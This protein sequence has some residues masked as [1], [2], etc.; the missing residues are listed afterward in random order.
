MVTPSDLGRPQLTGIRILVVD[1]DNETREL[2]SGSLGDLGA[3]VVRASSA[4]E[5]RAEIARQRPDAIVSD[6][7]MPD[8]DGLAFVRSLKNQAEHA[9][10]TA[11]ASTKD[12]DEALNAGY[13]EHVAKPVPPYRLARVI[14]AA[15]RP[16]S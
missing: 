6:I 10:L 7:G 12:R 14:I 3:T 15:L 9:A 11:Y 16:P 4:A 8:E 1:D 5:A 13:Q 2:L